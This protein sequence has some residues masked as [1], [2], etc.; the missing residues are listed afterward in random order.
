[1]MSAMATWQLGDRVEESFVDSRFGYWGALETAFGGLGHTTQIIQHMRS[2]LIARRD[3]LA[4]HTTE[5]TQQR[6]RK[7]L[8]AV[9]RLC[10]PP[11]YQRAKTAAETDAEIAHIVALLRQEPDCDEVLV[12]DG[13]HWWRCKLEGAPQHLGNRVHSLSARFRRTG[14]GSPDSTLIVFSEWGP[15]A[16]DFRPEREP[17]S[18][19][20]LGS[21]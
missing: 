21:L 13:A 3:G 4:D 20:G 15:A 1:M 12:A 6:Y 5:A 2:W 19:P 8:I 17:V 11:C 16:G 7:I 14:V 10:G 9:Q 18:S